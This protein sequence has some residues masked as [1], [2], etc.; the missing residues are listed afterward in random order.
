MQRRYI[1]NAVVVL[2][3]SAILLAV[4]TNANT[5]KSDELAVSSDPPVEKSQSRKVA[6]LSNSSSSSVRQEFLTQNGQ[7]L[8]SNSEKFKKPPVLRLSD[9]ECKRILTFQNLGRTAVLNNIYKSR[10]DASTLDGL[11]KLQMRRRTVALND[12]VIDKLQKGKYKIRKVHPSPKSDDKIHR[13]IAGWT[14]IKGKRYAVV[15]EVVLSEHRHYADMV[16]SVDEINEQGRAA[17][18]RRFNARPVLDRRRLIMDRDRMMKRVRR[19]ASETNGKEPASIKDLLRSIVTH[20]FMV[21]IVL[22]GFSIDIVSSL[23]LVGKAIMIRLS[24]HG[25]QLGASTS[26]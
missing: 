2:L 1:V 4:V 11:M 22:T 18:V 25:N 9:D 21:S 20:P 8:N 17:Y 3:G 23:T 14:T 13:P 16:S 24:H 12:I 26:W 19:I 7:K 15:V 6:T 10:S 5:S